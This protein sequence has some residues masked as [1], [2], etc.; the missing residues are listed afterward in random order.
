MDKF[1]NINEYFLYLEE[2]QHRAQSNL[3]AINQQALKQ[4][5]VRDIHDNIC[6]KMNANPSL[7]K[8]C[9]EEMT[10]KLFDHLNG[11]DLTEQIDILDLFMIIKAIE[12]KAY[13]KKHKMSEDGSG[14]KNEIQSTKKK[15]DTIY[16]MQTDKK[17]F[18]IRLPKSDHLI[19]YSLFEYFQTRGILS[20]DS[21]KNIVSFLN[22]HKQNKPRN[23]VKATNDIHDLY[24]ELGEDMILFLQHGVPLS[25]I[26]KLVDVNPIYRNYIKKTGSY[27][28]QHKIRSR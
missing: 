5:T 4:L 15:A 13:H 22:P 14:F 27:S 25:T 12:E 19:R 3:K 17:D 6:L 7:L 23:N 11:F 1:S 8:K 21:I 20:Y 2:V 24:A 28:P 10:N 18:E 16:A 9:K 26:Y